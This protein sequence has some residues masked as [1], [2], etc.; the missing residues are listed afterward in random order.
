MKRRFCRRID[1][2]GF[3]LS[4]ADC[5][6]TFRRLFAGGS[7]TFRGVFAVIFH[8]NEFV[9]SPLVGDQA[10]LNGDLPSGNQLIHRHPEV[11][12]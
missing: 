8:A 7:S 2:I 12:C 4:I 3:L 1:F 5:S 6:R 11:A 9:A 10:V